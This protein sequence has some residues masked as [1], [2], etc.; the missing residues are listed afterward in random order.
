MPPRKKMIAAAVLMVR[1]HYTSKLFFEI[2]I[3]FYTY[4]TLQKKKNIFHFNL[5]KNGCYRFKKINKYVLLH[6]CTL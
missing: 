6:M 1:Y 3:F 2:E 5:V 4:V